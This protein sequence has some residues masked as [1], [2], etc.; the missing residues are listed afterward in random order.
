METGHPS[1]RIVETGLNCVDG[2]LMN[3]IHGGVNMGPG[4][5]GSYSIPVSAHSMRGMASAVWHE[6]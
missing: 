6:T 4:V 3:D 2:W 5:F 1:T